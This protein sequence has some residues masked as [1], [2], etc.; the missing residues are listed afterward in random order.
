MTF[1]KRP[2]QA[3]GESWQTP[4]HV[5]RDLEFDELHNM[6]DLHVSRLAL[7]VS[8]TFGAALHSVLVH[9]YRATT[10]RCEILHRHMRELAKQHTECLFIW[11]L[12]P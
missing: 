7:C 5:V 8:L 4:L 3:H 10:F 12:Y 9:F 1:S 6:L 11:Y 2:S